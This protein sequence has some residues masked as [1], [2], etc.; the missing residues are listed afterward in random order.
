MENGALRD[1]QI[2][3]SSH[4]G[5]LY[6]PNLARLH[7]KAGRGKTGSWAAGVSDMNQWLQVNFQ[8][9]TRVTGIATQGRDDAD[10]WVTGY[11]LQYGEDGHT[12]TFYRPVGDNSETVRVPFAK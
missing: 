9:A 2:S 7:L 3:A 8:Q 11:K 12:F 4:Y 10:Q 5:P 6:T 1:S